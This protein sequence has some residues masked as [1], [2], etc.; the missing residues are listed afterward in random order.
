VEYLRDRHGR[1]FAVMV[2]LAEHDTDETAYA[3]NVEVKSL[4]QAMRELAD[5]LDAGLTTD[6]AGPRAQ[7]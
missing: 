5:R 4:A 2:W 7:G 6:P 1:R 3:A